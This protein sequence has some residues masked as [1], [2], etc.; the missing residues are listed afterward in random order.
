F[1]IQP[2]LEC[3][4]LCSLDRSCRK[5]FVKN[6]FFLCS[7][8]KIFRFEHCWDSD[9][10][11]ETFELIQH[12]KLKHLELTGIKLDNGPLYYLNGALKLEPQS[13]LSAAKPMDCLAFEFTYDS[14]S[15]TGDVI[16]QQLFDSIR[17]HRG[18]RSIRLHMPWNITYTSSIKYRSRSLTAL[19]RIPAGWISHRSLSQSTLQ[20]THD[21][22]LTVYQ[23]FDILKYNQPYLE[24]FDLFWF[25]TPTRYRRITTTKSTTYFNELIIKILTNCKKLNKLKLQITL[26]SIAFHHLCLNILTQNLLQK[27]NLFSVDLSFLTKNHHSSNQFQ[28]TL[29]LCTNLQYLIL[30]SC[31]MG[32]L[33]LNAI[34]NAIVDGRFSPIYLDIRENQLTFQTL[35]EFGHKLKIFSLNQQNTIRILLFLETNFTRHQQDILTT[36]FSTCIQYSSSNSS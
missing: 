4:Q 11:L 19:R 12:E 27:L 23:L 32:N 28:T 1:T 3:L 9:N 24:E 33:G 13:T 25:D 16:D 10:E 5:I 8:V 7:F 36:L 22:S 20:I 34:Q 18:I 17:Y 29:K 26:S 35:I 2:R 30:T 21:F 6:Y 15:G 31:T 14:I